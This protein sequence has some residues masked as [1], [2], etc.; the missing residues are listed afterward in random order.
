MAVI[1]SAGLLGQN[2]TEPDHLVP[3]P[4]YEHDDYGNSVFHTL[5]KQRLPELY[6]IV[7]PSFSVEYAVSIG[8][9]WSE[10]FPKKR[11]RYEI[12]YTEAKR[13]IWNWKQ[14]PGG[15]TSVL[16]IKRDTPINSVKFE[17]PQQAAEQLIAAW[18]HVLYETK[19][20]RN[21]TLGCDGTTY[22]FYAHYNLFGST[23]SPGSGSPLLMV[24]LGDALVE[25][26]RSEPQTRQQI[27][28][29]CI[30]LAKKVQAYKFRE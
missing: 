11:L 5:I 13:P 23:W 27:L 1:L 2:Q 6:M 26:A 8:S 28:P 4:A 12:E 30:E 17:I 9:I 7:R 21:P 10:G 16:D 19:Y 14:L 22:E 18:K 3:V 29:K 20:P 25:Y 15:R 24:E